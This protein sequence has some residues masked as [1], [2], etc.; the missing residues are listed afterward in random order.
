MKQ[1]PV[2]ILLVYLLFSFSGSV[3]GIGE[4][5]ISLGGAAAWNLVEY[6]AGITQVSSVRRYPV[7][8]LSSAANSTAGSPVLS[9]TPANSAASALDLALSFDERTPDS[10]KDSTNH[11][12]IIVSP[13]LETTDRYF[14]RAGTGAALFRGISPPG[15]GGPLVIEPQSRDALFAPDSHIRDFTLEFWLYPLNMENG[16][17]ILSWISSR[18]I[19]A[20]QNPAAGGGGRDRYASQRIQC[21]VSKNRLQWSFIGFFVSPDLTGH[22]DITIGG[23]T[24]VVPKTWSHHLIRFDSVTGMLEY[25]VNGKT[26]AIEYVSPGSREGGEVYTPVTGDSGNFVLGGQFMGIMDEFKIHGAWIVN[27]VIQK[28]PLRGGRMETK[29]IDLGEGNSVV[30]KV[31]AS[32]GRTSI[33]EAGIKGEFRENGRFRFADDSE[34]QFFIRTADNPYVWDDADWQSFTPGADI[35]GNIRGRYVQLAV[36]FYPSADSEASPYLEEL[37]ITYLPDEPPLPPASLTAVAVDG[38]VQLRWKS[39]PDTDTIG[40]LV[41]YGEGRDYYFSED[42]LQGAS[43]I[44]VGKRNTIIL[45]GFTNGTLYYFRVAAYDRRTGASFHA[46]EFSREVSARPL[47]G[48][49]PKL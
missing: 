13:D 18:S 41:Y 19:P 38:G 33:T 16:E 28:Y 8:V 48:L 39:S 40:Y 46:G 47:K 29:A 35:A 37:R 4:K 9:V 31:D 17:Q 49:A 10:F 26:E 27:P 21:E 44:D 30:F 43:P 24:P 15:S 6:R 22:I 20:S 2:F 11:Y 45:D 3:Y 12:R 1:K 42:A 14:P 32:G 7:L 23:T 36:D 34:L 25:M 5:T